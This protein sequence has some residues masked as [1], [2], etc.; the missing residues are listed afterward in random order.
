MRGGRRT[1][2]AESVSFSELITRNVLRQRMRSGLTILG[3]GIGVMTVIALGAVTNGLKAATTDMAHANGADFMVAQKGASDL[4]FSTLSDRDLATVKRVDGV[5]SA[6]GVL[7]LISKVES[8]P[9]F[10]TFGV[11]PTELS[12]LG[13]DVIDGR[14]PRG[15]AELALGTAVAKTLE[16]GVG[17]TLTVERRALEVVGTYD[18]PGRFEANG[19]YAPLATVR[20]AARKPGALTIVYVRAA[21][22]VDPVALAARVVA[23]SESLVTISNAAEYGQ[24]DQGIKI[25]DAA[26]MAISLLAVLVGAIGVMNTMIMSVFERT[27]EIG[28][29][30]AVGWRASR[31]VRMVLGESLALCLIAAVFG[32]ALGL[33]ATRAVLL[34]P[35]VSAFLTPQYPLEIFVRAIGV[36][37]GVAVVGALYPAFRAV[38]LSPMEALRHE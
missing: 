14:L 37:V 35:V 34:V 16:I 30:R 21:K 9:Y 32:T 29:L 38:R 28:I 8:V 5:G 15:G 22:G 20:A 6:W 33:L 24:V 26:N 23:A 27:R 1:R 31:V 36:A 3:I 12:G 4:S 7:M 13:V 2:D 18:A 10:F 11:D 25:L 17:D 19:G